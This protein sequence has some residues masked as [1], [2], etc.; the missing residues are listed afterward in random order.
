MKSIFTVWL[1]D[2]CGGGGVGRTD[3]L[4]LGFLSV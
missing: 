1:I 4:R 2:G 3:S